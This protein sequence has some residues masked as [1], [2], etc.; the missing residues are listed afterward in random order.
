MTPDSSTS[1]QHP[2]GPEDL[3]TAKM[4]DDGIVNC[5]CLADRELPRSLTIYDLKMIP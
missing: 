3:R 2:A 1:S 4:A 5:G